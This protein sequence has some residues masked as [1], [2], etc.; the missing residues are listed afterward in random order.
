MCVA[1]ITVG[2]LAKPDRHRPDSDIPDIHSGLVEIKQDITMIAATGV[3]ALGIFAR[4]AYDHRRSVMHVESIAAGL[5]SRR[6]GCCDERRCRRIG[7]RVSAKSP[8]TAIR[9]GEDQCRD[10]TRNGETCTEIDA[11]QVNVMRL[12]EVA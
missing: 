10:V 12:R 6:H 1:G 2:Q 3:H 4:I 7:Q 11:H 8:I 9:P 5:V